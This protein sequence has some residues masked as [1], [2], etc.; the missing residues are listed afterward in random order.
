MNF[1]Q[2]I[3]FLIAI[4][5]ISTG[6]IAE[7]SS[8]SSFHSLSGLLISGLVF[9][10][11]VNRNLRDDKVLLSSQYF[12]AEKRCTIIALIIFS[13]NIYG[14]DLLFFTDK[15]F[16]L[17]LEF[18]VKFT[19]LF[20]FLGFL[21]IFW[22]VARKPYEK[23][24]GCDYSWFQ[25][26]V[27]NLKNIL[28]LLLPWIIINIF[29]DF[30]HSA[31]IP[32]IDK[33]FES[34]WGEYCLIMV[35][36][37]FM[38]IFFP[39]IVIKLWRCD[40]LGPGV[41]REK[42]EKIC[43]RHELAYS[44][45]V[46][47]NLFEGRMLTAGIMGIV[48]RFRYLLVTSTLL[49]MLTDEEL[50][51]VF[52][53]EIGHA[54][55][56]HLQLY[57]FFFLGFSFIAMLL[58]M[59]V[60]YLLLR[61]DW[62]LSWLVVLNFK[63]QDIIISCQF[64]SSLVLIIIYF[65]FLFGYF[66]RNFERQADLFALKQMPSCEPLCQ[67]FEKISYFSGNSIDTPNWHHFSIAERIDS[68]KKCQ[69]NKE[70]ISKHDTKV[71]IS[72]LFYLL[73]VCVSIFSFLKFPVQSLQLELFEK[74]SILSLEEKIKENPD[75]KISRLHLKQLVLDQK[76]RSDPDNSFL[77]DEQGKIF[78]IYKQYSYAIKYFEQSLKINPDNPETANNI[79]W[80]LLT[81]DDIEVLDP[82]KALS[83]AKYATSKKMAG[84]ILDTLGEAFW[85]NNQ[86]LDAISAEKQA[87]AVDSDNG[88]YYLKQIEK[89]KTGHW[90]KG[91][92]KLSR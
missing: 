49:E 56:H 69:E 52:L 25:F 45:I 32:L 90:N 82:V 67:V 34:F 36:F 21:T 62:L 33:L 92:N 59:G 7:T 50:E 54:K 55:K 48:G 81:A 42:I 80:V 84:Y 13:L 37:L 2:L 17:E 30:I 5:V 29:V 46:Y 85:A 27:L 57:L 64:F 72:L 40:S 63:P 38:A 22:S 10:L 15:I 31:N 78:L 53:H 91:S 9:F 75:D 39:V 12:R 16:L 6:A 1:D 74:I 86:L 76:I 73:V 58:T 3:Y 51:A 70:L 83:L 60:D 71:S 89:F 77:Y 19:G 28:P 11:I 8:F 88:K 14:L 35:F 79:A 20:V 18:P 44:D 68:L 4:F 41:A 47:W 26:V 87:I 65:R 66:M 23:I 24:F 61:A 43:K